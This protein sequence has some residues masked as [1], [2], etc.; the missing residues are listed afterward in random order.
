MCHANL[1]APPLVNAIDV[2][3]MAANQPSPKGYFRD[4]FQANAASRSSHNDARWETSLDIR[5]EEVM[6]ALRIPRLNPHRSGFT[7]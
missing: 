1:Y 6:R 5:L 2:K 4:V 3:Y 7:R